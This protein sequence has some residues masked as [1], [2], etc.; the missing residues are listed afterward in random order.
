MDA[1]SLITTCYFARHGDTNF[2]FAVHHLSSSAKT[3]KPESHN[4]VQFRNLIS[5]Q[6]LL[7]ST[8]QPYNTKV[9]LSDTPIRQKRTT[10]CINS[11]FTQS[12]LPLNSA[13]D[14]FSKKLHFFITETL[15]IKPKWSWNFVHRCSAYSP[16]NVPLF[17]RFL[18]LFILSRSWREN[19]QLSG[20]PT[21]T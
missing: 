13:N 20:Q 10:K 5:T 19:P 2:T 3:F 1:K 7:F 9:T 17:N 12:R 4:K 11:I 6:L 15:N 16:G 21:T 14:V 18:P 8:T